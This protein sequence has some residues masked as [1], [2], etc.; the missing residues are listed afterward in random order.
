MLLNSLC[1]LV[2]LTLY[3]SASP[4]LYPLSKTSCFRSRSALPLSQ[5]SSVWLLHI[6]RRFEKQ[7]GGAFFARHYHI[8]SI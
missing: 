7:M 8:S 5:L 1:R 6:N 3:L 2:Y 4:S